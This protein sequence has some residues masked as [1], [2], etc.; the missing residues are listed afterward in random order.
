MAFL[1][2]ILSR[3]SQLRIGVI[4][5]FCLD[6]YWELD[7][8]RSGLSLET[9][10]PTRAVRTQRY[11]LGGAGNVANN[12]CAMGVGMVSVY[13]VAGRDPFGGQM[14]ELML[15]PGMDTRGLLEQEHAWATHTYIKPVEDGVEA[16]RIDFGNF[17]RLNDAVARRV[18]E[19]VADDIPGL[20]ALIINQQVADGI[21]R[22]ALF[23]DGLQSLIHANPTKVILLDSRDMSGRYAGTVRK[24]NAYEAARLVG[25]HVAPHDVIGLADARAAGLELATRWEQPVFLSRGDRGCL[26]VD[27][28]RVDSVPGLHITAQTDPVGAGD[29]LLAG[30]AAALAAGSSAVEAASFGNLVAGITVQKLCQTGTASPDEIRRI[31]Q[32]PEYTH[33]PEENP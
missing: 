19:L 9:G 3:L 4:G 11:S 8:A 22:S 7:N 23:Q 28:D 2:T 10:L 17:N 27:G 30:I 12:L 25:A 6:A 31:G 20:D 32:S 26:V 33:L 15:A 14:R 24:L 18:L 1:N 16:S 29:S 5:D 13:G 21:H